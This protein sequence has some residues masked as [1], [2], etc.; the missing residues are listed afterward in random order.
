MNK[1]EQRQEWQRIHDEYKKARDNYENYV[2]QFF[3]R[4]ING[5]VA[6][7]AEKA[8]TRE[9]LDEIIKLR[10]EMNKKSKAIWDLANSIVFLKS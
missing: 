7:E 1:E 2:N 6:Q 3:T 8:L 4:T 5:E 10:E 9:G